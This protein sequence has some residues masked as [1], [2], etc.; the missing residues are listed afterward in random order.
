MTINRN[1][2]LQALNQALPGIETGT[3]ILE[4]ADAFIFDEEGLHSYNDNISIFVPFVLKDKK[5]KNICGAV[6]A[7]DFYNLISKLSGDTFTLFPKEKVWVIKS[8]NA[9]AELT[10]LENAIN[11]HIHAM[12]PKQ[13]KWQIL[14]DNFIDGIG[15]CLF[16]NN[17][18]ILAGVH[19]ENNTITSTD[20]IRISQYNALDKFINSSFWITD[21]AVHELIKLD[22]PKQWALSKSWVHFLTEHG[23]IFSCKQLS[24]NNYPIAKINTVVQNNAQDPNDI[25]GTLPKTLLAAINRAAALSKNI[26]SFD[27]VQLTFSPT[28]IEVFTQRNSGNY[29]EVVQWDK[30]IKKQFDPISIIV[31][32]SMM[33]AG[34]K[35]SPT[36]YLKQSKKK[37]MSAKIIL[38]HKCGLQIINTFTDS[39]A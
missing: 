15:T 29:T 3:T 26:E 1:E 5:N 39:E 36:F 7:Q 20:E 34:M 27:T 13:L 16:S 9:R 10:L 24:C 28:G 17:K 19:V 18:S 30:P 22:H 31:D 14:A 6:K 8:G 32:Y 33:E 38:K 35:Y 12:V 11:E 21:G 25:E 23:T 4:G 37:D 2:F